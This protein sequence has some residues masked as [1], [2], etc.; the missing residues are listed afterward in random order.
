MLNY[1]VFIKG[2]LIDLVV[3]TEEIAEK[4][5][6]YKW[7]NDEEQMN[8]T[9]KHYFPNSSLDQINFFRNE[10]NGN[11]SKLQVGIFHK[12]DQILIGIVSLTNIDY[13]HRKCEIGGLIGEKKYQ[14]MKNFV[15][16]NRLM[17]CHA[18]DQLNMNR[19]YGGTTAKELA[20]LYVR[21]LGFSPEG[22][23]RDYYFKNG[24]YQDVHQL[25]LLRREFNDQN[26]KT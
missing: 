15:E 26:K 17:I 25:S 14:N 21:I 22:I 24:K 18:F 9:Q 11:N 1:D 13:L 5:N 12:E 3:L 2:D 20:E 10:I 16:A 23:S 8:Q 4:S 6:W 19:I 7:F